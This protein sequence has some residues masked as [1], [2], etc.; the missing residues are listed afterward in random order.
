MAVML[1]T[2]SNSGI[3]HALAKQAVRAGFTVYG[4]ARRPQTFGAIEAVGACPLQI[5]VTDS[6]TMKQAVRQIEAAH[7]AVDVLVNNAGFGQLGPIEDITR[8]QWSRQ[9][10]TNVFGLAEMARL[11]I[12][13]MRRKQQGRIINISSMGGLFTFPLAGAYHATKYAVESI[14][15]AMR[16]ELKPFGIKV[17]AIQPGPVSTPL[18]QTAAET[19]TAP[20]DSP[21]RKL[22]DGVERMSQSNMGYVTPER[23]ATIILRA[24]QI[25][26]PRTRYKVGMMSRVLPTM[27]RLLSDGMWD[28]FVGMFY[29]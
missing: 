1:I 11:V 26:N 27:H 10:E 24:A 28:R 17:I 9:F 16:F 14:S 19:I 8:E 21:Y 15:D 7:G 2:G 22:I 5:D 18:A 13:A 23:T 29:R 20:A 4:G 25:R 12:P 6:E 3:G